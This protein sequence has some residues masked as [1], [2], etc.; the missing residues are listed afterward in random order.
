[1]GQG[2]STLARAS[3]VAP[4]F[5]NYWYERG[6]AIEKHAAKKTIAWEEA[7]EPL[8]K[9]IEA[10]PDYADCYHELG[11]VNPLDGQRARR[12]RELHEGHRAQ[13]R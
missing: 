4:K 11:W 9:C 7:K 5:A 3:Q 8:K 12:A 1:M 2:A 6:Y 10:D 13:A